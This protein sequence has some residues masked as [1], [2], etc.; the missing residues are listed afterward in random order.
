MLC[1]RS[2]FGPPLFFQTEKIRGRII[3]HFRWPRWRWHKSK[4]GINLFLYL[5]II[6]K[7]KVTLMTEMTLTILFAIVL[8]CR[9]KEEVAYKQ[10]I[11][12]NN[13]PFS[14]LF[15]TKKL[16]TVDFSDSQSFTYII[17]PDSIFKWYARQVPTVTAGIFAIT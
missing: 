3:N 10:S 6:V 8:K 13:T 16:N 4:E 17:I 15:Q 7:A 9:W 1:S 11:W 2:I 5:V 14:N 12:T